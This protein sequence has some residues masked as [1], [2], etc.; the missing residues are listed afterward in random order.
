MSNTSQA[1]TRNSPA[2]LVVDDEKRIADTL[3][4]IL[5]LKGYA[6][7]AAY[8]G[9]SALQFCREHTPDLVIS[10][11]VMPKLN[12]VE[13]AMTLRRESLKCHV[14]LFSGQAAS[15]DILE[16]AQILGYGFALL[17][18]PVHPD[19]LLKKVAELVGS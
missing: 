17:A 18:K 5:G 6:A 14:V 13:L 2:I 7:E 10:D 1:E 15:A 11:V 19:K 3:K 4:L 16:K 12:G 9:L 8:D